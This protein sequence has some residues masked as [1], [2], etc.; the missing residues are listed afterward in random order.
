MIKLKNKNLLK[1]LSILIIIVPLLS[2]FYIQNLFNSYPSNSPKEYQFEV[3]SKS[4]YA[5]LA[6]EFKDK[7]IIHNEFIFLRQA[8]DYSFPAIGKYKLTLPNKSQNILDQ[9]KKNSEKIIE[10]SKITTFKILIK[11]GATIDDII[12][13]FESKGR[14]S[15]TEAENYLKDINN[16]DKNKFSY[17]PQ[18]LECNYGNVKECAKYLIEGY[19]YP[20]TYEFDKKSTFASN[21]ESILNQSSKKFS[22]LP[23]VPTYQEVIKASVIEKESGFGNRSPK[24]KQVLEILNNERKDIASVL[25]NRNSKGMKWQ[26]NPSTTYGTDMRLCETT[27]KIENCKSLDDPEIVSNKYN[28]Y[29]V[30]IPIGPISNPSFDSLLAALNPNTSEYLFFIADK[31]GATRFAK[32]FADFQNIE[33]DIINER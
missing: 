10:E 13:T 2:F 16:F 28:A 17:L 8:N 12:N 18:P 31:N 5:I 23:R 26:V 4:T 14:I 30:N 29:Q 33:Q 21:I 7:N 20:A 3:N 25:Y 6:K 1:I 11:E 15:R 22:S 32:T 24:D 27:I 9:I 19:I